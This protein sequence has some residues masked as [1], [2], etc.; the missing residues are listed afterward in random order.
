MNPNEQKLEASF[1]VLLMSIASSAAI[2][3]GLTPDPNTGSIHTN[4][5]MAQF[6]ID[7]L[8]ILKEKSKNNLTTDEI[9]LINSLIQDLQ[10]KFVQ[11]KK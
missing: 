3:L 1:S 4:R 11:L 8:V 9:N 10:M 7:L 5:S 2:S 6:N